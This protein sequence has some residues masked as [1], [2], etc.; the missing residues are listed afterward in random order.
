MRPVIIVIVI[1]VRA[2]VR[3]AVLCRSIAAVAFAGHLPPVLAAVGV[4]GLLLGFRRKRVPAIRPK[5][6]DKLRSPTKVL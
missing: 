6:D 4:A 2:G 1:L 3:K 5:S